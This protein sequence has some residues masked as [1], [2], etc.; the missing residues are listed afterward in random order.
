MWSCALTVAVIMDHITE[1]LYSLS[2]LLSA[3]W[4]V[5]LSVCTQGQNSG[6]YFN[7]IILVNAG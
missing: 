6:S 3:D 5:Y 7:V 2:I 1:K 4:A